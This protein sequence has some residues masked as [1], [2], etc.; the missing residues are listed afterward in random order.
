MKRKMTV[1][2]S[3]LQHFVKRKCEH[4]CR[5]AAIVVGQQTIV[6]QKTKLIFVGNDFKRMS[7]TFYFLEYA[8]F[9]LLFMM[10]YD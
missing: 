9:V 8:Q 10:A 5:A 7:N 2:N 3:N 4:V 6:K 1:R